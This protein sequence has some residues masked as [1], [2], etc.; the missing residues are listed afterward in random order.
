MHH[1]SSSEKGQF[2]PKQVVS[3]DKMGCEK[4]H[5][6]C[7]SSRTYITWAE[8]LKEVLDPMFPVWEPKD[9]WSQIRVP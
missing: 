4:E 2:C 1:T 6:P 5:E 3:P 7:K 8:W 9:Y